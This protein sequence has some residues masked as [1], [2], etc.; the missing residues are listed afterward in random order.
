MDLTFYF[1]KDISRTILGEKNSALLL[2]MSNL[3]NKF[4]GNFLLLVIAFFVKL[5]NSLKIQL[6]YKVTQPIKICTGLFQQEIFLSPTVRRK[7]LLEVYSLSLLCLLYW[8]NF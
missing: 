2:M 3:I 8:K 7:A 6:N 1:Y 5:M 4:F